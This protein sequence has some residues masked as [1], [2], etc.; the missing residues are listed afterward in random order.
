MSMRVCPE[1]GSTVKL[2]NMKRHYANV[3]PGKDPSAAISD[4]EHREVVRSTRPAGRPLYAQ[5]W[6]KVGVTV[7]VLAAVG[8]VGLPYILGTHTGSG[9]DI[10]SYCGAEGSVEHYHPLLL[11]YSSGQQQLLP[12]DIG[13]STSETNPAYACAGGGGHVLHT[14]DGSGIIHVELPAVPSS[15]PTLGQFFMIWGE[16]LSPSAVAGF[17]GHVTATMYDS[18]T[19]TSHD[20]SSNPS[21]IPLYAPPQGPTANPYPIPQG[22]TWGGANGDGASGGAFS[23]EIVWLNV[24][25]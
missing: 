15:S 6:F 18:D 12:A 21:S 13:I 8:Y 23:G 1:C 11:I 10:V 14:H 22:L 9:L 25:A 17:S 4:E 24:T 3:H 20:F 2:E 7:I 19:H 16:A 5:A